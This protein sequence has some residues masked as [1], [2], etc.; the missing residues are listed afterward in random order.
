ML[1]LLDVGGYVVEKGGAG[2]QLVF[3]I[4]IYDFKYCSGGNLVDKAEHVEVCGTS[5]ACRC[6]AQPWRN[7]VSYEQRCAAFTVVGGA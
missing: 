1:A 7:F 3:P 6:D 2:S 5:R 4:D